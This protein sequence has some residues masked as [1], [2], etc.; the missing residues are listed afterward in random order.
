VVAINGIETPFGKRTFSLKISDDGKKATLNIDKLTDTLC[1]KI[2]V[3]LGEWA[4]TGKTEVIE[5]APQRTNKL[6][7][8]IETE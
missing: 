1:K 5:L 6:D 3:H 8:S 4:K 2:V 7:I